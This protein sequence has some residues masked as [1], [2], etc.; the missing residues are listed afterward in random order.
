MKQAEEKSVIETSGRDALH[1]HELI[2]TSASPALLAMYADNDE[3]FQEIATARSVALLFHV[4]AARKGPRV[5]MDL[6]EKEKKKKEEEKKKKKKKKKKYLET[7]PGC[8]V[9]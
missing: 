2:V 7:M 5:A 6:F 4:L 8:Y 9:F 3:I 1:A